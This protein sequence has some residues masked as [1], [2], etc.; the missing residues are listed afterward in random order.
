M[1]CDTISACFDKGYAVGNCDLQVNFNKLKTAGCA[2]QCFAVF[3]EGDCA[4]KKF[5]E[6]VS[7]YFSQLKET[8]DIKEILSYSDFLKCIEKG[9]TGSLLTVENLGFT[10]GREEE[11]YSLKNSGVRMASLVWNSENTL[12]YPA[13]K[14]E[15]NKIKREVR[16][17]KKAGRRAVEILDESKIIVDISHLSDGGAEEIL[18]GRK[19]PIVAS[20]SNAA[21]VCNVPRNLTD[22]LIKKI[23][24][25]G[26]IVG[27]N[28]C[29]KFL[30]EGD[31]FFLAYLHIKHI[32]NVGGEDAVSIGSDFDG[33]PVPEKF[34]DCTA[35]P[36]FFEYLLSMGI[37]EEALEKICYKNFARVLKEVCG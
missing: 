4:A 17:L 7:F 8:P 28:F 15:N 37:K 13:A 31:N 22:P 9:R 29:K 18:A 20:H 34:T 19:I 24:D 26:G 25:C 3:T 14:V 27:V 16:G 32:I 2:A 6:Y 36:A 30:G 1:H 11:I 10:E 21:K 35:L 5:Y 23:A 33:I 12:A